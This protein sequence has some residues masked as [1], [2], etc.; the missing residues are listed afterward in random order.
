MKRILLAG[1]LALGC[2]SQPPA[3]LDP[4][5]GAACAPNAGAAGELPCDVAA[6]LAARCQ[7]CHRSPP[8]HKAPFPLLTYEDTQHPWGIQGLQRWQG[9]AERVT[10]PNP[11][12]RMPPRD[13]PQ[14]DDPQMATL[15]SWFIACAPPA[16]ESAGCDNLDGGACL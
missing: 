12:S 16:P 8:C 15:R 3:A 6:V 4:D 9:M 13:Q 2:A 1:A 11:L 10:D 5:G 7:Q 14:L